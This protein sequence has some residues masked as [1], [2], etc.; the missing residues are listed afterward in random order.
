[1]TNQIIFE[2]MLNPDDEDELWTA[3]ESDPTANEIIILDAGTLDPW[4]P[5]SYEEMAAKINLVRDQDLRSKLLLELVQN[6]ES[7]EI[8][9]DDLDIPSL[10]QLKLDAAIAVVR[11]AGMQVSGY[12]T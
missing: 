7:S 3:H 9:L 4:S 6:A 8:D 1:M 5:S 2:N 10:K 11:A 12:A